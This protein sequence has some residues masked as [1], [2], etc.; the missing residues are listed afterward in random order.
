MNSSKRIKYVSPIDG[1]FEMNKLCMPTP[2]T[3][4]YAERLMLNMKEVVSFARKKLRIPPNAASQ[5]TPYRS[6][7]NTICNLLDRIDK[8]ISSCKKSPSIRE[9]IV[10][11]FYDTRL[12]Q[13]VDQSSVF[14]FGEN[15][16]D[17]KLGSVVIPETKEGTTGNHGPQEFAKGE[18]IEGRPHILYP[19]PLRPGWH[20]IAAPYVLKRSGKP[21]PF[22]VTEEDQSEISQDQLAVIVYVNVFRFDISVVSVSLMQFT[23]SFNQRP[24]GVEGAKNVSFEKRGIAC[25]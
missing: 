2:I 17:I 9:T 22:V 23:G 16:F 7:K 18:H 4:E 3:S 13:F 10:F 14:S 8:L 19:H 11:V 12:E 21:T 25:K 6:C 15:T 20:P 5:A 1:L 24:K